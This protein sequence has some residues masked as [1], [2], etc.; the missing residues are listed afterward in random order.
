[1]LL[2]SHDSE[3][4]NMQAITTIGFDI[5][6]SVFVFSIRRI[7]LHDPPLTPAYGAASRIYARRV[8]ASSITGVAS[9]I[10]SSVIGELVARV[11]D[12]FRARSIRIVRRGEP[13]P[14][15]ILR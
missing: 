7:R 15:A 8:P 5:A 14:C 6:K 3:E 4:L 2:K 13:P 12:Y 11:I 10:T 9:S 1:V